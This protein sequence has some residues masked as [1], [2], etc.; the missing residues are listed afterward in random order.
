[1]SGKNNLK[2]KIRARSGWA[3]LML[4]LFVLLTALLMKVDVRAIGP[5]NSSVGLAGINGFVHEKLGTSDAFYKLTDLMGKA[6]FLF[7]LAFA[8]LG[9]VQLVRGRSL[10]AVDGSLYL[11]AGFYVVVGACYVLFEKFVVNCR[12][13]LENG[14]LAEASFPSSHTLLAV[15]ILGSAMVQLRQR[16]H[17]RGLRTAVNVVFT[18]LIAVMAVGRLLS[19]HWL[20]DIL[21]GVLLGA[22]LVLAYDALTL[23]L[24]RRERKKEKKRR[25]RA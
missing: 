3:V 16:L 6:D 10:K 14:Q 22:A 8:A 20:T 5:E 23:E 11:L 19:V 17:S 2:R 13:V 4:A 7:V 25:A 21:G 24:R 12:P 1:M 18:V 9:L 15:T